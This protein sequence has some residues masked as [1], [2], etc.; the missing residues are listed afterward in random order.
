MRTDQLNNQTT[1]RANLNGENPNRSRL[2]ESTSA[3]QKMA[4]QENALIRI[5]ADDIKEANQLSLHCPICAGPVENNVDEPELQPVLCGK[6]GTLYHRACWEG[7]GGTCAVL[8]CDHTEARRYGINLGPIMTIK[9]DEVPSDAQVD[10]MQRQRLKSAEKA[11][12]RV[13][14]KR[15]PSQGF[16][17][18]LYQR[19]LEAFRS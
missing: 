5:T 11:P 8:G 12:G 18:R 6:C 17:A 1:D 2:A 4:E 14:P 10:R 16:W 13:A 7:N 9:P 15:E 19:I 3:R